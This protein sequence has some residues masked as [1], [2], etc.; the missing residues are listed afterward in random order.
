MAMISPALQMFTRLA[1]EDQLGSNWSTIDY[2]VTA[3]STCGESEPS[4]LVQIK[5]TKGGGGKGRK[6]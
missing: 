5:K 3:V 1:Y 6:N 4:E 2:Y